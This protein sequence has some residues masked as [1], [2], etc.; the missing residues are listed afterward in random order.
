M[1]LGFTFPYPFRKMT[2]IGSVVQT[3][4]VFLRDRKNEVTWIVPDSTGPPFHNPPSGTHV[5]EVRVARFPHGRDLALAVGTLRFLLGKRRRIDVVHAHQPHLQTIAAIFCARLMCVPV[6]VTLHGVLPRPESHVGRAIL[7]WCEKT[8]FACADEVVFVSA[9]SAKA[10]SATRGTVIHN[11]VRIT[12]ECRGPEVR[13][14][15]RAEWRCDNK[16]VLLFAGRFSRLKGV[17]DLV[18]AF[19]SLVSEGRD[20]LLVL[21]GGGL[22]AE[23]NEMRALISD[24]GLEK[25]ARIYGATQGYRE[26]LLGADLYVFPSYVEGLP[27]TLL[28]AMAAGLPIVASDVGGIP[29]AVRDGLEAR[30]IRPGD[31]AELR[32]AI[33]WMLDHP[34]ERTRMG[35]RA[36][37]RVRA[38]FT[39]EQM[40]AKYLTVYES[41]SRT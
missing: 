22:P 15:I 34:T 17:N 41:L 19:A 8:V 16:V 33:A 9:E 5:K 26:Y 35:E 37:S 30:L 14:R 3:L 2:G 7:R 21:I 39:D 38:A 29:E 11:G 24:T 10:L 18:R 6:V 36:R 32:S 31:T 23:E 27:L 13:S 20:L 1:R 4:T 40:C 12:D 25:I 28:E